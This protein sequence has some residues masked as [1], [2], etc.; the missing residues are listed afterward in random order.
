MNT[1][2]FLMRHGDVEPEYQEGIPVLYGP[3]A[4]LSRE[5]SIRVENLARKLYDSSAEID[6]IYASLALRALQTAAIVA[7]VFG[8]TDVHSEPGLSETHLPGWIGV[9]LSE[10]QAI[11]GDVFS[12]APRSL[13]QETW[14]ALGERV[15]Q[16][17]QRIRDQNLGRSV[18]LISHDHPLTILAWSLQHPHEVLPP[19]GGLTRYR[20]GKGEVLRLTLDDSSDCIESRRIQIDNELPPQP[21]RRS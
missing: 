15:L 10:F 13:D 7:R 6:I 3:Q 4:Q 20:L 17:Y 2:F 21:E 5:G 1:T 11:R 18:V 16:T 8:V 14:Q 12:V 19:F 9:P